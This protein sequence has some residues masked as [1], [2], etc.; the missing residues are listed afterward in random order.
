MN[1]YGFDKQ[2]SNDEIIS[3][4]IK[5]KG[6]YVLKNILNSEELKEVRTAIDKFL[7]VQE[8][9]FTQEELESI[10]E[11]NQLRAPIQ[12]DEVFLNI[13]LKQQ[14]VDFVK[15]QLGDYY[16]LQQQNAV[17]NQPNS[18]HHQSAWHRD[19]PYQ[20]LTSSKPLAINAYFCIDKFNANTGATVFVPHTHNVE[21]FPSEQFLNENSIQLEAEAG[22]VILFDTMVIHR[23]GTNTSIDVR[24][25]INN[26]FSRPILRQQIDYNILLREK[27]QNHSREIKQM[28]GFDCASPA[29]VKDFRQRFLDRK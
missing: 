16:I 19:L 3:E 17:I 25:G 27:Y 29:S 18:E 24:R 23:A 7:E 20:N 4:S 21:F 2:N 28:L 8:S 14:I 6:Y 9:D 1:S 26:V 5:L 22:D 12:Y 15:F 10:G 11:T 13:L